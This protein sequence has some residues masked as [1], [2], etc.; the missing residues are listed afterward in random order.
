MW[1]CSMLFIS[2]AFAVGHPEQ[3]DGL[4]LLVQCSEHPLCAGDV[5]AAA[6]RAGT[7]AWLARL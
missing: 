5:G 4:L 7:G 6:E 3:P 2:D 1:V